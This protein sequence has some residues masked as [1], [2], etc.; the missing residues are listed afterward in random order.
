MKKI[1]SPSTAA[2]A[3]IPPI[4][5]Q[6]VGSSEGGGGSGAGSFVL[7]ASVSGGS[8]GGSG[9]GNAD[10]GAGKAGAGGARE[11]TSSLTTN[12]PLSVPISMV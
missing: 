3:I 2:P 8:D 7:G 6:L 12:E 11:A 1:N 5:G 4:R 9:V 10:V